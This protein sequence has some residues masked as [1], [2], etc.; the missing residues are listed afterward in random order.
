MHGGDDDGDRRPVP[1]ADSSSWYRGYTFE[2]PPTRLIH[3][4]IDPSEIGR[5]YPV[6]IGGGR[7][8]AALATLTRVARQIYPE[9]RSG[10]E[11]AGKIARTRQEFAEKARHQL[12][13]PMPERSH[14]HP[15]VLPA[16][17]T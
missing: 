6:E 12:R 17:P 5:N 11:M 7:R 9:G 13:W 1:E 3:I 8:Q 15:A 14:K 10:D 16:T 2:I 4:D